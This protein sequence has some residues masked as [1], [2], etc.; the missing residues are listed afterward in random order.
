MIA[1]NCLAMVADVFPSN[2]R[3]MAMGW[4]VSAS[5]LGTAVGVPL[6]A[7]LG[8]CGGWRLPFCVLGGLL[9]LVWGLVWMWVPTPSPQPG[10]A[11]SLGNPRVDG[12]GTRGCGGCWRPTVCRSW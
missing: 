4:L 9:G 11:V 6:V 3:G 1:P 7:L 8:E 12:G 10:S 2:Q 5:G